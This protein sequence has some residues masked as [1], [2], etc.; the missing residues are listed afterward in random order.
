MKQ[1][2]N[3]IYEKPDYKKYVSILLKQIAINNRKY[4]LFNKSEPVLNIHKKLNDMT[5][6]RHIINAFIKPL[7]KNINLYN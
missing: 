7:K 6:K 5:K 2:K 3:Y 4:F 1:L